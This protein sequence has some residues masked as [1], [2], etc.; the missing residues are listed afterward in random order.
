[1]L[2]TR[3]EKTYSDNNGMSDVHIRCQ[4]LRERGNK[5]HGNSTSKGQ[6]LRQSNHRVEVTPKRM[7]MGGIKTDSGVHENA[8]TLGPVF[9][10]IGHSATRKCKIEKRM[11]ALCNQ[12]FA[13]VNEV[14]ETEDVWRQIFVWIGGHRG[15]YT[16][17]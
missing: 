2:N 14:V 13:R 5:I 15:D 11:N 8:A 7:V 12:A 4:G 9:V 6:E 1:M 17:C 16:L 3:T 10:V